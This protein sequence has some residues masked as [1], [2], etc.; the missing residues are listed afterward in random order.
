M[1]KVVDF[2]RPECAGN[3]LDQREKHQAFQVWGILSLFCGV[4]C[5]GFLNVFGNIYCVTE[6]THVTEE[7]EGEEVTV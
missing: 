3:M 6:G 5:C 4:S 7:S 1:S 2:C